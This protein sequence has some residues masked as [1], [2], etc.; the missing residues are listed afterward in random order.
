M[1]TVLGCFGLETW[2]ESW[3]NSLQWTHW[4]RGSCTYSCSSV[5]LGFLSIRENIVSSQPEKEVKINI[6]NRT[7]LRCFLLLTPPLPG[8]YDHYSLRKTHQEQFWEVLSYKGMLQN[9]N[10]LQTVSIN[11][12]FPSNCTEGSFVFQWCC[13]LW[14]LHQSSLVFHGANQGAG[15]D[16]LFFFFLLM[17]MIN[18]IV[19]S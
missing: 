13:W 14:Q 16:A 11:P 9:M 10:R 8:L 5:M 1:F 3:R 6:L 17:A 2:L 15:C 18:L 12:Y 4:Q 19:K 7:S